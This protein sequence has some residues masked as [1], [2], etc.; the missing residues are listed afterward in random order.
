M[1]D[2]HVLKRR[3]DRVAQ[4]QRPGHIRR[5]DD[6]AIR[7]AGIGGIGVEQILVRPHAVGFGL[8]LG[9]VVVFGEVGHK[10]LPVVGCQ[11]PVRRMAG[12]VELRFERE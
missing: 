2:Q 6:D 11:L 5:R 3:V 8:D 9:G 12:S 4:V 7:L 1:A 10:Q